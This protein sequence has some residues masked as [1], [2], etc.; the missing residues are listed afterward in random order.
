M[1]T[2]TTVNK[3]QATKATERKGLDS[4][5]VVQFIHPSPESTEV[6]R[7]KDKLIKPWNKS[8]HKRNFLEAEGKIINA[9]GG[10]PKNAK[11]IRFWGE[12]E[13]E[14]E[15]KEKYKKSKSPKRLLRPLYSSNPK[16]TKTNNSSCSSKEKNP[17]STCSKGSNYL[18]TDPFV[19]GECFKYSNCK[20][21]N[22]GNP[23]VLHNLPEGSLILFGSNKRKQ[24]RWVFML[25]TVFVV[26]CSESFNSKQYKKLQG[27]LGNDY[28]IYK[29]ATLK[30]LSQESNDFRLYFGKTYQDDKNFFSFV[31]CKEDGN[32]FGKFEITESLVP[33]M[34]YNSMRNYKIIKDINPK[35]VW[36]KIKD[37]VLKKKYSLGVQFNNPHPQHSLAYE[38]EN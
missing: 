35:E 16:F 30:P 21:Y 33:E 25:D 23:T 37:E 10:K 24:N 12:W 13:L 28:G 3:K 31:P 4:P 1:K 36:K 27:K 11:N 26:G 18:N 15:I 8:G 9:D 34:S 20:Q 22:G 32:V 38:I 17:C 2:K 5:I 19:F 29:A 7:R 6:E 14:A